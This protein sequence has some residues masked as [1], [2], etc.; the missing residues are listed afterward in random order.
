MKN[1]GFYAVATGD[2]GGSSKVTA[3]QGSRLLSVLKSSFK[4]IKDILPDGY[5]RLLKF[6]KMNSNQ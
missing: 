3:S 5:R 4:I 6:V 2:I 1:N